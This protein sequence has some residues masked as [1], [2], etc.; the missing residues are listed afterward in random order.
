[1]TSFLPALRVGRGAFGRERPK[2]LA[3]VAGGGVMSDNEA[4]A[5]DPSVAV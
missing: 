1:M 4:D 2:R 3:R 5:H